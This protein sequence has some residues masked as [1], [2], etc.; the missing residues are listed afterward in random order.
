LSPDTPGVQ[1]KM[2]Y[3]VFKLDTASKMSE[4][5]FRGLLPA[6]MKNLN[7][8]SGEKNSVGST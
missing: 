1:A 2:L 3:N 5:E 6:Y 4:M 7:S 8:P